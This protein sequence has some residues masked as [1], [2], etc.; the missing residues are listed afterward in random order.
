ML[1]RG[2]CK[3]SWSRKRIEPVSCCALE[4]RMPRIAR[5]KVVLPQPD[6]PTSPMISPRRIVTLTPS[7]TFA[8]PRSVPN[9][10]RRFSTSRRLSFGAGT[11][12]PRIENIAQ[13]VTQQV[14]AH[15]DKE[16][17]KPGGQ[18][19]PPRLRKELTRFGNHP[20]PFR[21]RRWCAEAK[22]AECACCED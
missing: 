12:D 17:R 7:S 14:E 18:C 3:R 13:A 19:I 16:D 15:H 4:G 10:T 2:I 21:G 6:S 20:P 11:S 5:A 8:T 22:E 9:D 1:R